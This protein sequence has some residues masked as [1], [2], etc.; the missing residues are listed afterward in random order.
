MSV[1]VIIPFR[2]RGRDPRRAAN[3]RHVLRMWDHYGYDVHVVDDGR[4]GDAQFN[5]HAAYNLG[6]DIATGDVL[7]YAEADMLIGVDQIHD[8]I[9]AAAQ[10]P[11]LV[12]P[13][14]ERHE[15][16][17]DDTDAVLNDQALPS[18]C[19]ATVVMP[20]PRRIGCINVIS[21][22]TLAAVGQWDEQF[23]GN[24][25]D[26]RS[27]HRAFDVC[28]GPTRWIEGPAWHLY[29]LPGHQ[30]AHLTTADRA[31]TRNNQRRWQ[32][33]KAATTPAEL[34]ALTTGTR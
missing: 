13:F 26:D 18:E 16:G 1:S 20:K 28:A 5:R 11:G 29:H 7:V 19:V 27:M 3:L 25:W 34:R 31:A 12:V 8:A 9:E 24:W 15:L 21:R 33:Y 30:G 32:Q 4:S 14:T 17:P 10:R 23:E 22:R 2:D 6:A